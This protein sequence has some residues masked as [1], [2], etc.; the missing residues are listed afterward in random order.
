[1]AVG[2]SAQRAGQ[3]F[4]PLLVAAIAHRVV[5]MPTRAG[6]ASRSAGPAVST[7]PTVLTLP[8]IL[9]DGGH[10]GTQAERVI[11]FVAGVTHQ[12]LVVIARLSANGRTSEHT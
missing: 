3:A 11:S 10:D 12:H 9:G 1:M 4:V 5:E 8:A 7:D 6:T 2:F